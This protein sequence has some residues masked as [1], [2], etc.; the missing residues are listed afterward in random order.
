MSDAAV[1]V[2]EFNA[3]RVWTKNYA[4]GVPRDIEPVTTS[5]YD[6]LADRARRFADRPAIEFFGAELTFAQLHDHVVRFANGLRRIGVKRGDRVAIVLPNCPQHVIAYYATLRLGAVVVEHNPLY[7]RSELRTQYQDHGAVFTI[8]WDKLAPVVQ[9]LAGEVDVRRVISVNMT[10]MMPTKMQLLLKLPVK[11]ARESRDKLTGKA[12]GTVPFEKILHQVP[13]GDE[14]PK[15]GPD[16]IAMLAY[17]SGTTGTPKGAMLSHA[18]LLANGRQGQAWMPE[19]TMGEETIYAF[20]PMFHSFGNLLG[21]IYGVVTASR[22][23]LFPSFDPD[24]IVDAS[25]VHPA[26]F[27]PGV[28]PMF[29]RLA[30]IAREGRLDLSNVRYAMSGA[31]TLTDAVVERWEAVAGGGLNEGYGLTEASPI[32]FSNP[33]GPTRKIGTIGL[34][35]ASTTI[36]VVNPD[37]PDEDVP[38]GEVG[39]LIV[40]GPQVF[41]GYWNNQEETDKVLLPGRW[42]RTGDLVTQDAD[43]FITVVDRAKELIITGGYNVAPSEVEQVLVQVPGIAEAAV[44]GIQRGS[45]GAESV[46]AA[47]VLN[48][49]ATFDEKATRAYAHEHLAEFKVPRSYTVVDEL[50]KSLL[51]KV[52]RKKVREQLSAPKAAK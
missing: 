36:R 46:T 7:T 41:Q 8:A 38:L 14:V 40:H 6:E 23:T 4:P 25:K 35:H 1:N 43:G 15:P 5:L 24:L 44:V 16:D 18:N 34:P 33:F 2:A 50:P 9:S 28:P 11:K 20:L 42:L 37:N 31:M 10:K 45:S 52:L 32:V 29:D 51:G 3:N 19:F 26:T 12:P 13:I 27:Y 39:E 17:T 49:G 48:E 22:V 47:I 30:R 21:T